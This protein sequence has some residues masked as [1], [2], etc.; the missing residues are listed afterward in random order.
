LNEVYPRRHRRLAL[1][2]SQCGAL[3]SEF[4]LGTAPR[5]EHFPQRN[6]IISGLSLGTV[7]VEA[8]YRSGSLI[9]ARLA[10]RLD[11]DPVTTVVPGPTGMVVNRPAGG[12]PMH[13]AARGS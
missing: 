12:V 11:L 9:T 3:V 5:R 7:V 2:V 4:P 8:N 6:R 13:V 10:Q 1:E